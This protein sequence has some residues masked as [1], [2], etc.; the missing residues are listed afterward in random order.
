VLAA[1]VAGRDY[2]ATFGDYGAWFRT[3]ADCLDYL[4]WLRWPDGFR[5]PS[6]GAEGWLLADGR[7]E[8]EDC[9]RRT[10]VT[11]DTI[12]DKTRTPMSVWFHAAWLFATSKDGVSALALRRQLDLGSVQ[13]AWMILTRLRVAC[14]AAT[15]DK[16]SG[17]VEV[18]ET[19]YGGVTVGQTG[20]RQHGAKLLIV[21]A[22]E[23]VPT[24]GSG[25]CR[26]AVI[27]HASSAELR[28]FLIDNVDA[29]STVITD[30]WGPY[31]GACRGLY[32]HQPHVAP[33]AL[34]AV[35]LPGAH[36]VAALFKRWMLGT[37]QGG[38]AWSHVP[39]YLDEFVFRF[40][41]CNSRRR[42]LVFLRLLERAVACEPVLYRM[43]VVNTRKKAVPPVPPAPA[44]RRS[45]PSLH[46]PA[47]LRP[48]RG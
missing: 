15:L 6:C 19:M 40:N 18:D 41:R 44:D 45:T 33:G 48:W 36:R 5:C 22:V 25:R 42:G 12:F 1:P 20:G 46:R 29:G 26:M 8:C 37:H 47:V 13:T 38:V 35:Y 4:R 10:S 24:G 11:A 30:G 34:A 17:V 3:D 21:I 28:Q 9:H 43:V 39:L 31:I 16:L 2:P 32:T 7:Y 14:G 23:R 27:D